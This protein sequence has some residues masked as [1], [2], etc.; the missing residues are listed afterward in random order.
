MNDNVALA[1]LAVTD[2]F[3]ED[4]GMDEVLVCI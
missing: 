2:N 1:L 4:P 3:V